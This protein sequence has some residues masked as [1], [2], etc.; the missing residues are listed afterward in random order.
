MA[1]HEVKFIE[2]GDGRKIPILIGS[3]D[4]TV[5][6][7]NGE[8]S[9][10]QITSVDTKKN[11]VCLST[12]SAGLENDPVLRTNNTFNMRAIDDTIKHLVTRNHTKLMQF[13]YQR[14]NIKRFDLKFSDFIYE[15]RLVKKSEDVYYPKRY[16]HYE[17]D[18]F[19]HS[20][21]RQL[22]RRCDVFN[23]PINMLEIGSRPSVFQRNFLVFIDGRLCNTC[24]IYPLDDRIGFI[25]DV[26]TSTFT[27]GISYQQ[28][29]D[30]V[31]RDVNVTVFLVPNFIVGIMDSN[32]P[33]INMFEGN[34]PLNRLSGFDK[35]LPESAA[36]PLIFY[37]DTDELSVGIQA[38][39][40]IKFGY[41][42]DGSISNLWI[43]V[44]AID[45]GIVKKRITCIQFPYQ[46]D[47]IEVPASEPCFE[48]TKNKVPIPVENM[49][50]MRFIDRTDDAPERLVFDHDVRI[51]AF[52]PNIYAIGNVL[53]HTN[54]IPSLELSQEAIDLGITTE[55]NNRF[56][57]PAN[58]EGVSIPITQYEESFE[59]R[60]GIYTV[61]HCHI[62]YHKDGD[63]EVH[64]FPEE[65]QN[66]V[67]VESS[68]FC[69][70][71]DDVLITAICFKGATGEEGSIIRPVIEPGCEYHH[72]TTDIGTIVVNE[73]IRLHIFYQDL[74]N[75]IT[76]YHNDIREY[77]W[78]RDL[79]DD[80]V[81]KN[82]P[83]PLIGYNQEDLICDYDDYKKSIWTPSIF[84]YK[85]ARLRKYVEKYPNFIRTYI[86]NVKLPIEKYY[87]EMENIDILSRIRM[88]TLSENL[89][90]NTHVMF[91][92]PRVVFAMNRQFLFQGDYAFRLFLDGKFLAEYEYI[93]RSNL[94]FYYIYLKKSDVQDD[95]ILEI[96]RYRLYSSLR[97]HEFTED[98]PKYIFR[99]DQP[100]IIQAREIYLADLES[101]S[102]L[103]SSKYTL[104]YMDESR[105]MME[106]IDPLSCIVI[107]G[108]DIHITL[109][110]PKYFSKKIRL[111]VNQDASMASG[112]EYQAN[113]DELMLEGTAVTY[114]KVDFY[115][116]G[117]FDDRS[118][119]VFNNGRFCLPIQYYVKSH[120]SYGAI[121][122]VRTRCTIYK[123]DRFTVDHTP[124]VY[125]MVFYLEE[126]EENGYVDLD[127]RIPLPLSLKYYDIYLNGLRLNRRHIEIISP[128]KCYIKNVESRR[129]FVIIERNHDDDFLFLTSFAYKEA[130]HS[131]AP[132]DTLMRELEEFKA[133]MDSIHDVIN[134]EELDQLEGGVISD[135]ALAGLFVFGDIIWNQELNSNKY[136]QKVMEAIQY[137]FPSEIVDGIFRI[138]SR[139]KIE[140]ASLYKVINP[141]LHF[142]KKYGGKPIKKGAYRHGIQQIY[143]AGRPEP[144]ER[145]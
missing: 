7:M 25:I 135:E 51:H 101:D 26:A 86:N 12:R 11:T 1:V 68:V 31:D 110:D 126:I 76:E 116:T 59:L 94:D 21:Q 42:D 28:F 18:N 20:N 78:Y 23:E 87:I 104:E 24:E 45:D 37:N 142:E 65:I 16:T 128:T 117:N 17:Y 5:I 90:G 91:D 36:R 61:H 8:I 139:D 75:G 48:M 82:V 9:S 10:G 93:I 137:D 70:V 120:G 122:S 54:Q 134:D 50:P 88:N 132:L 74:D 99:V 106:T 124:S 85:V 32:L 43:N 129:N 67:D 6:K 47:V 53:S 27:H 60:R 118:Y 41:N 40:F 30:Y 95:S 13:E 69:I 102:Y 115:N 49:F 57:L 63:D 56:T 3:S 38:S 105:N 81:T 2:S 66:S 64:I 131:D 140:S 4:S 29:L 79:Y 92:E 96:E 109:K 58:L 119:R 15:S 71:D 34:I 33:T 141:N 46:F 62:E 72:D 138:D 98:N 84:N 144:S 89:V 22:Y 14:F 73:R 97:I 100:H 80:Y 114:T 111:G 112:Q 143:L 130:G 35:F 19:I 113:G 145:D 125:R 133:W 77:N 107:T 121:D 39:E 123:G 55:D 44:H 108:M 127:G 52:Y 103:D 83:V 136:N